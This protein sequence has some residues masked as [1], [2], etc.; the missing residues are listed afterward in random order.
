MKNSLRWR[1]AGLISGLI[2]I[3]ATAC[4]SDEF[5]PIPTPI[6][7]S[8]PTVRAATPTRSPIV[9]T[10]QA[11]DTLF[12]IAQQYGVSVDDLAALNNLADPSQISIGQK[13]KIPGTATTIIEASPVATTHASDA[14]VSLPDSINGIT[15]DQFVIMPPEVVAHLREI[16]AAGQ[17]LGRNPQAFSKLGDSTIENP[18][19]L[20]RFDGGP[21]NL[22]D[23]TALQS[24]IDYYQ[25]SFGRES[26]AV[27]RGLH[28]WTAL[29]PQWADKAQCEPNEGPLPCEIRLHNPSLVLIR[30]GANDGVAPDQFRSGLQAVIDYCVQQG[31]IPVIG[32]KSDRH[33]DA[34]DVINHIQRELAASNRLPLWDFDV[35]ANTLPNRGIAEGDDTH[36]MYYFAHDYSQPEAFRRGHAVHNLTALYVLDRIQNVVK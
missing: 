35:V 32:T 8:T 23:Y 29:N 33:E 11:G 14:N 1:R 3:A 25:G 24:V 16:F 26:I 22:G 27:R 28:A 31:V 20:A 18:H 2:I 36:L 12:R 34:N 15:I 4:H 13:L 30:L 5:E 10:V 6:A 19:F 21:Y 17:K 9:H 7:P